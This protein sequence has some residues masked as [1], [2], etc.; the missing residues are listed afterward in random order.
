MGPISWIVVGSIAGWIA[1]IIAGTNRHRGWL[2]NLRVG[3]IGAFIGGV[4]VEFLTGE[5]LS[6]AFSLSTFNWA[7]FAAAVVGAVILLAVASVARR[8]G[9]RS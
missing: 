5:G 7:S 4:V 6:S 2:M 1:G 3:A 8:G 9:S